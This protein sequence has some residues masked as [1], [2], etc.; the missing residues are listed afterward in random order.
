[1]LVILGKASSHLSASEIRNW[2]GAF[3]EQGSSFSVFVI[4]VKIGIFDPDFD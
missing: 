2:I 3:L 4:H 1:M